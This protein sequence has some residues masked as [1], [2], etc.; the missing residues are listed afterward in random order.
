MWQVFSGVKV[1]HDKGVVHR[2]ISLENFFVRS[3]GTVCL[4]DYGQALQVH[5]RVGGEEA[6][7]RMGHLPP[8]KTGY[9]APELY[10]RPGSMYSGKA[11]DVF[12]CGVVLYALAVKNYP[13]HKAVPSYLFPAKAQHVDLS[14]CGKFRGQLAYLGYTHLSEGLVDL[15]ERL[16]APGP[17]ERIT[18]TEALAHP[19]FQGISFLAGPT[20]PPA[21]GSSE[22]ESLAASAENADMQDTDDLSTVSGSVDDNYTDVDSSPEMK[23]RRIA[24]S[25]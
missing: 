8:G 7:I 13:F 17:A 3:N 12:A 9:R 19:W 4:G 22:K 2:D 6:Q 24:A 11:A 5:D 25:W 1:L 15:L 16:F 20:A 23:V 14:R 10:S 21:E 18:I